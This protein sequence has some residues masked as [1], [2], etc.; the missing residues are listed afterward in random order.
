[1]AYFKRLDFQFPKQELENPH[2]LFVS[3]QMN[4]TFFDEF[5]RTFPAPIYLMVKISELEKLLSQQELKII[6][7]GQP[8]VKKYYSDKLREMDNQVKDE[9][10]KAKID[11]HFIE[12]EV[13][14]RVPSQ[15]YGIL[16][17]YKFIR[18]TT[19]WM[20]TGKTP[21]RLAM[22]IYND[23]I[24]RVS[25]RTN[26]YAGNIEPKMNTFVESYHIDSQEGLNRFVEL[27]R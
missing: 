4:K 24:G 15:H 26:G 17:H 22:K 5:N 3:R 11:V 8:D 16:N 2:I 20:V 23:P 21:Y 10:M 1:M 14:I 6:V 12:S 27:V 19:Y 18:G 9:L 25:M 7:D 13:Y